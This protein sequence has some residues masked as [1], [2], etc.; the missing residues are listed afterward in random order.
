MDQ[1]L[2][3]ALFIHAAYTGAVAVCE[4]LISNPDGTQVKL[5]PLIQDIG[6][7]NKGV[8]VYE[9]AKVQYAA[10]L[11]AFSDK[12]GIWPDPV[13]SSAPVTTVPQNAQEALTAVQGILKAL[14]AGQMASA[15]SSILSAVQGL[16][17]TVTPPKPP[18]SDIPAP[19]AK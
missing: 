11:R 3:K 5:D 13:P 19:A 10:I 17:T 15:A 6:L 7:Q 9:E 12:T 1:D 18:G 14:P 16:V 4:P 8:L 2:L